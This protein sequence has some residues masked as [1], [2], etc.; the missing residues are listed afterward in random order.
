LDFNK[1]FSVSGGGGGG[2]GEHS[3]LKSGTRSTLLIS[4]VVRKSG[5]HFGAQTVAVIYRPGR[6]EGGISRR[7]V[8]Q[9]LIISFPLLRHTLSPDLTRPRFTLSPSSLQF[10]GFPWTRQP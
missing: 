9:G 4:R 8:S 2:G 7:S 5:G 10:H 3:A 1:A 6:R